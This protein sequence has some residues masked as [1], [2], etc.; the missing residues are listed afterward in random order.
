ML[1]EFAFTPA[2]FDA[3]A[4]EDRTAW[5]MQLMKLGSTM[6]PDTAA[7]PV[8]VSDLYEGSW[9]YEAEKVV[10]TIEDQTARILCKSILTKIKQRLVTRPI[11]G[12]WPMD[13]VAW[14]REAIA[15]HR[16]E[17]IERIVS[18]VAT[19]TSLV[20]EFPQFRSLN[21]AQ[22]AGFW[23]GIDVDASPQ[24]AIADQIALLRKICLHSQWIALINPYAFGQEQDFVLELVASVG[25]LP[26]AFGTLDIEVH[27]K[28]R[29]DEEANIRVLNHME[30]QLARKLGAGQSV[31]LYVWPQQLD[32]IIVAGAY[33][34]VSGGQRRKQP[35]W[36]VHLGHVAHGVE[37]DTKTEWKLLRKESVDHWFRTFAAE[38]ALDK[39]R[40]VEVSG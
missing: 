32:R 20:D 15:S 25:S 17:P 10:G 39:P 22:D 31:F 5:I 18:C 1:T 26:N 23:S 13:D 16:T 34:T 7:W 36:G 38:D 37:R 29:D 27:A 4:H 19:K 28:E 9:F 11:C 3:S 14:G 2:I 8:V 6:F 33:T 30:R 24:M 12:E 40:A 21:E 35:R